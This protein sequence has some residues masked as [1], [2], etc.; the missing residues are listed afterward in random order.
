MQR[1][2]RSLLPVILVVI[3]FIAC[4]KNN[5][6]VIP[7]APQ[8]SIENVEIGLNNNEIG[9]IAQ[10]FHFNADITAGEKID[11]IK[12][13][14]KQIAGETYLKAWAHTVVWTQYKGSRN[15][16]VHKHFDM[17]ADAAE[18]KYDFVI[19]VTD[20]NGSRLEHKRSIT[21]YAAENVPVNP[22]ASIFNLFVNGARFY[23][24][25]RFST[26]DS[27]LNKN[28]KLNSQ[29]TLSNIKGSGTMYLL[30]IHKK[31]NHRPEAIDKIDFSKVIVYDVYDH[32]DQS[33]SFSFSNTPF[34]ATTNLSIRNWPDM[35]I[36]GANDNNIPP[37]VI[38]GSRAWESGAYYYG[39][40]YFN[41]TYKIGFYKYIE[42]AVEMN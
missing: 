37:G 35:V 38:T 22:S 36:G 21:I 6:E 3:A 29:V 15:T 20:E 34:D 13:E 19:T 9:I 41:T 23:R 12:I 1:I 31:H 28:D 2:I 4:N 33:N 25:G 5:D 18:G 17:P 14:I 16:N 30:L 40:V 24:N 26:T 42:L 8:P 11:S 32:K 10:D 7:E 39:V 27:V